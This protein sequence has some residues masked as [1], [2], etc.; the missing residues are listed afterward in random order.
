MKLI[1]MAF[2]CLNR[3]LLR[4]RQLKELDQRWRFDL[5]K[6]VAAMA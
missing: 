1:E 4:S 3:A 6:A 5:M 2:S